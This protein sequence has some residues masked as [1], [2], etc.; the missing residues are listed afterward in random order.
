M[1]VDQIE[2]H[3]G[4]PGFDFTPVRRLE[5]KCEAPTNFSKA[6]TIQD[7][8]LKLQQMAAGLG[9]DAVVDVAYD[10][11]WS[12]TSFRSLKAT[13][14]AVRRIS[15]D[16]ACP[17]CAETIKRA[18][19]KCRFCGSAL[20]VAAPPRSLTPASARSLDAAHKAQPKSI[21]QQEPLKSTD[22]PRIWIY[23]SVTLVLF[24]WMISMVG[25]CS[26]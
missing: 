20:P 14:L 3:V 6:P 25:M 13:G 15:D 22:N 23:V 2:I 4:N 18:A 17:F 8:N 24:V 19:V 16:I 10:S 11:G 5:A 1:L 26:T 9:A 7:A 12:M 21:A